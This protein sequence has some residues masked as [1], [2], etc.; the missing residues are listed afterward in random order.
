VR[1]TAN[2][3]PIECSR[4]TPSAGPSAPGPPKPPIGAAPGRHRCRRPAC[5]RPAAGSPPGWLVGGARRGQAA[6]GSAT[7]RHREPRGQAPAR[8]G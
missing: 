4:Y 7:M 3:S 6:G 5:R 8:H 1:M 2:V